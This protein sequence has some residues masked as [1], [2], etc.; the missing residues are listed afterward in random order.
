MEFFQALFA[1]DWSGL[2]AGAVASGVG[3]TAVTQL[4]KTKWLRVPA[5]TYPRQV[6]AALAVLVGIISTFAT[7][8]ELSSLT[9]FAVFVVV[10]FIV[11]GLA[12]DGVKGLVGEV[13]EVAGEEPEQHADHV[14]PHSEETRMVDAHVNQPATKVEM[15]VTVQKTAAEVAQEILDGV[16]DWGVRDERKAKVAEA[17]LDYEEVANHIKKLLAKRKSTS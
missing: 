2:I 4:L 9:S 6:T 5:K 14:A 3:L 10:S 17:G 13:K 1:V 15:T 8:I 16:G 11:S 12:Y 7:G